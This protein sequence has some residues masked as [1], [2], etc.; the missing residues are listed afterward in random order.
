MKKLLLFCFLTL[1][2]SNSFAQL[3]CAAAIQITGDGTITVPAITG[4]YQ[5]LC[6]G[7]ADTVPN[8]IW[9]SYTA[10]ANGEVT[11][12]AN[13]PQNVAPSS[14]DQRVSIAT[15]T[16]CA[17][18]TCYGGQDDISD[19]NFY[20]NHTFPV[21]AGTTYYIVWDDRWDA[22]GF[23][24]DFTFN[25]ASCIRPSDLSALT[26]TSIT[27][28]S[29]QL[30]WSASIGTPA[31]YDVEYGNVDYVQGSGTVVNTATTSVALTGITPSSSKKDYYLRSNCGATQSGWVGPFRLNLAVTC[32]YSNNFDVVADYADGFTS[33]GWNLGNTNGAA[34]SGTI[35]FFVNSSTTVATNAFLFSRAIALQANEEVT[36]TFYTRL[37]SAT[38][39]AQ[40][41]KVW[42]NG[43]PSA[44]GASQL[45]ATITVSGATYVLQTRTFTATSAGTYYFI[46]NNATPIIATSTSLRLDTVS[47]S[48]V[49]ANNQFLA[50][51]FDVYPNPARNFVTISNTTDALINNAEIVDM[52]GRVVKTQ[53]VANVNEA[54]INIS[55]LAKGVYMMKISSDRGNL[56]KK[57]VIE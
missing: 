37:A 28:D 15:G 14:E 12:N 26:P 33:S 17:T 38:G 25:L 53:K 21:A 32:P 34:Q 46:L 49:L 27:V 4:T 41:L 19:T 8:A 50:T 54:Q 30:N 55:D 44:T 20:V 6:W 43:T 56:T 7:T 13:L 3:T 35:Y 5:A 29:S 42:V 48:S 36:L 51:N 22:N 9:Y 47:F 39:T 16:S 2:I 18:L 24:F 57:L 52:N 40:T 10:T 1:G 31:S 23:D 45:G 11:I